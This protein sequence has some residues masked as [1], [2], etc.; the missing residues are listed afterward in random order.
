MA[1]HIYDPRLQPRPR[2]A[3]AY[4]VFIPLTVDFDTILV[5]LADKSITFNCTVAK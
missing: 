4:D 5:Q 1:D 3:S 2:G